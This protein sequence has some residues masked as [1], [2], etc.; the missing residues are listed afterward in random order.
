MTNMDILFISELRID[1]EIG[2]YE[3][4]KNIKQPISLDIEIA[5]DAARAAQTDTLQ[6]ALDYEA[7]TDRVTE[8]ITS[9]HFN[10]VETVAEQVAQLLQEEFGAAWLRLRVAKLSA[11]K[12]TRAVGVVIER[13]AR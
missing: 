4:E 13:G 6:H 5:T 10:L 9:K 3:W 7:I 11:V 8:F 2:V 1:S 12:T